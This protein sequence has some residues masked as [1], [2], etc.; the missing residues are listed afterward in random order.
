MICN[1]NS[2]QYPGLCFFLCVNE[3]SSEGFPDLALNVRLDLR[4]FLFETFERGLMHAL[5]PLTAIPFIHPYATQLLT[6][7]VPSAERPE[8]ITLS[9]RLVGKPSALPANEEGLAEIQMS[10]GFVTAGTL[11]QLCLSTD[12]W[13]AGDHLYLLPITIR[14]RASARSRISEV[15][16]LFFVSDLEIKLHDTIHRPG[17]LGLKW[18]LETSLFA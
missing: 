4:D 3:S 1:D 5:G 13:G 6:K 10:A 17:I 8:R 18:P 14:G 9:P 2:Y 11:K 15:Q 12:C 16:K 7:L